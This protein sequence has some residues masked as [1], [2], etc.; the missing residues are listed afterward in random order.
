MR[1]LIAVHS[2]WF[3]N[4]LWDF[5]SLTFQRTLLFFRS[6]CDLA[7]NVFSS[8]TFLPSHSWRILIWTTQ[9]SLGRI[10]EYMRGFSKTC[11]G[12]VKPGSHCWYK[13]R[14]ANTSHCDIRGSN[15]TC[16]ASSLKSLPF[17]IQCTDLAA[18]RVG[19]SLQTLFCLMYDQC[20]SDLTHHSKDSVQAL[21]EAYEGHIGR[22][23][24]A[25]TC[26][27]QIC[28]LHDSGVPSGN[29]VI[30]WQRTVFILW[31]V[32]PCLNEAR[33]ICRMTGGSPA[34]SSFHV[35]SKSLWGA[36][37]SFRPGQR[38]GT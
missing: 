15:A 21:S 32:R 10:D 29:R 1:L 31:Y 36:Q 9:K 35:E 4:R 2:W 5:W 34:E 30:M 14:S 11:F 20:E 3:H 27:K 22:T 38:K 26:T 28:S 25:W 8:G 24:P 17:G 18:T 23:K 12:C 16:K 19:I 37:G 13:R 7:E 6:F 33:R